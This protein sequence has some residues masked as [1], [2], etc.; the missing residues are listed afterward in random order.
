MTA[1]SAITVRRVKFA[2]PAEIDP[3]VVP[4]RPEESF[5]IVGLSLLLPYLEPYL[6]RTMKAA[7][8]E[9]S[10]A[11]LR[12][13]I[14]AF[15]GQ[16]GQHYRQHKRFNDTVRLGGFPQIAE[17]EEEVLRDYR[18]FTETKS[19][20]WNLAYAEGFEAFTGAMAR[21][22]F[23]SGQLDRLRPEVRDLFTWHLVEE[24]EHSTVAF[25]AYE[26]CHGRYLYR[27]VVGLYAQWHLNRF[28]MRVARV[29]RDADPAAFRVAWGGP[30]EAWAR[31]RP[32][33]GQVIR[34][35]W[36]KIL[37]TYLPWYT[38]HKIPLPE[39]ARALLDDYTAR[40]AEP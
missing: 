36:P 9:V 4:G 33:F 30:A 21:F 1:P 28:V 39:R 23:E 29:F 20:A 16:E 12:A 31:L 34:L 10:D 18:R 38:P 32:L 7:L 37:A 5:T 24:L 8:R 40:S 2:F 6:I 15:N 19:L 22:S 13:D 3:V 26:S 27:L 17:L 35:L 11:G 25:D 14:E